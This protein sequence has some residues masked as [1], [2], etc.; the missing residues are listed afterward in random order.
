MRVSGWQVTTGVLSALC[1][2]APAVAQAPGRWPPDS[3]VNTQVY[4]RA[5]PVSQ[6][7]GQMRNMTSWL[8][9]RC[10]YCHIGE[11]GL[12]LERFDFASDDKRTKR[13]AREMM[14]L[15]EAINRD[16]LTRVPERP[17]PP[18]D[19]TC[20]TCHRG[21]PRPVPL[22]QLMVDVASTSGADS[23][24][25]AYRSLR[26]RYYGR[27][28]YDF[29]EPSLGIAAFRLGRAGKFDEAFTLMRLNE[30][31]FPGSS[32]QYVFR[33]NIHLM[34][35]DTAAAAEAFREAIRRDST[36]Q[37]ARGRLRAIGRQP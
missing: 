28:A 2:A 11:E 10:Q 30:E 37:E 16:H 14:R 22:H 6:V 18:L 24:V 33:G 8:G 9:V 26:E 25:R 13:T 5:T 34:R 21:V 29:S 1:A 4:P 3:L 7:I 31:L 35:S 27:A 32:V 15:V 19:V 23:A 17:Q 20:E 12:P 36:N